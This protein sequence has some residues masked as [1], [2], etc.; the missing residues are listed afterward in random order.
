MTETPLPPRF[1]RI[2]DVAVFSLVV[3]VGGVSLLYHWVQSQSQEQS[4]SGA[5]SRAQMRAEFQ[6]ANQTP[7]FYSLTIPNLSLPVVFFRSGPQDTV[8]AG[9]LGQVCS[10]QKVDTT[11]GYLVCVPERQG[12]AEPEWINIRFC[13]QL[14]V[15]G[16]PKAAEIERDL[17]GLPVFAT[18]ASLAKPLTES[19]S[20]GPFTFSGLELTK[21]GDGWQ[22]SGNVTNQTPASHRTTIFRYEIAEGDDASLGS[23][24]V[25]LD[26]WAKGEARR[27]SSELPNAVARRISTSEN[28][29]VKLVLEVATNRDLRR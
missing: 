4:E 21:S 5:E 27:F 16:N 29:R 12:L 15:M 22:L 7:P 1:L 26:S 13:S 17:M 3:L 24:R 11:H 2:R 18:L 6:K 8:R 20:D 19:Q 10:I 25:V 23:G 9:E 14:T 28:V